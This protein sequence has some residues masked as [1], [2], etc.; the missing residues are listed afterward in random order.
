MKLIVNGKEKF[1]DFNNDKINLMEFLSLN[2]YSI[3][4]IAVAI[5]L[6]FV[7]KSQYKLTYLKDGDDIEIVTPMQGG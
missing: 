1:F 3:D 2:S 5:N 4:Y 6:E 7:P